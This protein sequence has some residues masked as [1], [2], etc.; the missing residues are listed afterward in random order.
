MVVERLRD[1]AAVYAR[2]AEKGRMMPDGV[3]YMNS[4]VTPDRARCFQVM[5]CD[6]RSQLEI[7]AAHWSDLVD[8]EFIPVISSAEA[9]AIS[10]SK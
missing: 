4:W 5:R 2:F 9:A 1:P 3:E 8:F 7:W 6:E 10:E